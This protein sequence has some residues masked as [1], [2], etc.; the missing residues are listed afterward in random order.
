LS[1]REAGKNP[2]LLIQ[3]EV[4][5]GWMF[6]QVGEHEWWPAEVPGTV[7]TDLLANE[8]IE[9][10]YYRLNELD[11][12]WIDKEDWEYKTT[13]TADKKVLNHDRVELRFKG[14][15]TYAAIFVN[16]EQLLST[17][18]MFR[19]WQ[20]DVKEVLN[21]GENE[22]RIVLKSPLKKGLEKYDAN[23]FVYPG[24]ENDQAERGQVEGTRK[25]GYHYGWDW[26]P[27][28]VTSGIW[29]PVYLTAWDEACIESLQ[30][31]QHEVSDE[32]A[33]FTAVFEVEAEGKERTG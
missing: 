22:L 9:D 8:K 10:P 16:G 18:N 7:H 2:N 31:V 1:C 12:Q 30:I 14:L 13:F 25:A 20:I 15:D 11:L 26:G 28:L 5:E 4:S 33:S 32:K 24:A 29:R 3:Q 23:E 19:E 6:R 21:E 17:N 27:R